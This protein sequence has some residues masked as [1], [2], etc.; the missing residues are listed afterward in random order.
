MVGADR[1]ICTRYRARDCSETGD[2][3]PNDSSKSSQPTEG[4]RD[5]RELKQ[6]PEYY[7]RGRSRPVGAHA[8]QGDKLIG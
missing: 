8:S 6:V 2:D 3:L 1:G 4:R 7:A 5:M